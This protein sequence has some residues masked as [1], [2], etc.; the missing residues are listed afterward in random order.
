MMTEEEC[1]L[2][3]RSLLEEAS[4]N[5]DGDEQA[6]F[7]AELDDGQGHR[8]IAAPPEAAARSRESTRASKGSTDQLT[9]SKLT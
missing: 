3:M 9:N 1:A 4:C 8:I 7:V 2:V 6:Y 5:T